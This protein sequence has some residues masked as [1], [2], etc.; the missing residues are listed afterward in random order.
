MRRLFF[1]LLA[2]SL[3]WSV[4]GF[5]D[6]AAVRMTGPIDDA[7]RGVQVFEVD[8]AYLGRP[9][10]V[11]VLLPD[12]IEP[13][14]TYRTLYALPVGGEWTPE[15]PWGHPLTEL[16][17]IDAANRYQLIC[18]SMEFDTVPWYGQHATDPTKRHAQY[19][20]N[21][22]VPMIEE[23]FATTG[24]PADRLLLG[25]SKSGWGAVSLL[26]RNPDF[27]GKACA[28]DA[29]LMMTEQDLKWGSRTHFGT[30]EAA[31]PYVPVTAAKANAAEFT[32]GPK[33]FVLLGKSN[34]GP[35]V[36]KFHELLSDLQ[37]PHHYNNSLKV[38][39]H[40]ESGWMRQALE[41]LFKE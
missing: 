38:K 18:V 30:P 34:F 2:V 33:R 11:E 31:A 35:H 37:V 22:V 25:F 39:H 36:R 3:V 8:S 5:A 21:V 24:E 19:I 13:G 23:R 4:P 15:Q 20:K 14:K 12:K 7:Q 41:M 10:K 26:L 32:N 9:C 28:W 40:W 1:L 29:P 16:R 27:F 17:K 6:D